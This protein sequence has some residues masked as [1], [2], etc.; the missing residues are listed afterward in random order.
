L[1][2]ILRQIDLDGT[3]AKTST[4]VAKHA[5]PEL[6]EGRR[7]N[8]R[9]ARFEVPC[10]HRTLVIRQPD[11]TLTLLSAWMSEPREAATPLGFAAE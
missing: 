4:A 11:R 1:R 2:S 9:I 10:W 6:G 7:R 3:L 8:R 5:F